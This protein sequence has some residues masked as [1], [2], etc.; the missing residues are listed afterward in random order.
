MFLLIE[1]KDLILPIVFFGCASVFLHLGMFLVMTSSAIFL[2]CFPNDTENC[3]EETDKT[4]MIIQK[5]K[6]ILKKVFRTQQSQTFAV[7]YSTIFT[8][9]DGIVIISMFFIQETGD[10]IQFW[11]ATFFRS[12]LVS[13]VQIVLFGLGVISVMIFATLSRFLTKNQEDSQKVKIFGCLN[14]EKFNKIAVLL[15][16]ILIGLMIISAAI[17]PVFLYFNKSKDF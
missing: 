14:V 15:S 12:Y 17:F 11:K 4:F 9:T 16:F 2:N 3:Q 6:T 5:I 7:I 10:D 13:L 1:I 8:I